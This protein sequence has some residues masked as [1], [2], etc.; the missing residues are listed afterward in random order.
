MEL[1]IQMLSMYKPLLLHL[2]N[3]FIC[4]VP[5]LLFSSQLCMSGVSGK[6][7]RVPNFCVG[8][9]IDSEDASVM[10][11]VKSVVW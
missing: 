8:T 9:L 6:Y 3:H 10:T 2:I 11:V 1:F 5:C 7:S 4:T